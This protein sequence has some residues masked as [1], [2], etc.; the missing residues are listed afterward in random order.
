MKH[1]QYIIL[2]L[3]F[4]NWG[5]KE[6]APLPQSEGTPVF[7]P[8]LISYPS[9]QK[10]QL[11]WWWVSWDVN[12][13]PAR[14]E[15][16]SFEVLGSDV[17]AD[18][19]EVIGTV[20]ADQVDYEVSNVENGKPYYFAIRATANGGLSTVSKTVMVIPGTPS[21]PQPLIPDSQE[22]R[23]HASWSPDGNKIA[24]EVENVSDV[25]FPSANGPGIYIFDLD[26]QSSVFLVDG[27]SPDWSPD[28]SKIALYN[29]LSASNSFDTFISTIDTDGT[30]LTLE[31]GGG[32]YFHSPEWD[33][34]GENIICLVGPDSAGPF[35]VIRIPINGFAPEIRL[36]TKVS[37]ITDSEVNAVQQSP[38]NPVPTPDG[39]GVTYSKWIFN[40]NSYIQ[41][42]FVHS[43]ETDIPLDA[44]PSIYNDAKPAYSPDGTKIA[45]LSDRSGAW[46]IWVLDIAANSYQQLTDGQGLELLHDKGKIE[47][48][49]TE[50]RI[51]FTGKPTSGYANIY[52]LTTE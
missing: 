15:P 31:R 48:H 34:E 42:I 17:S 32:E 27:R 49:P 4:V 24:V 26:A 50:N 5:C 36:N 51:L 23:V 30:S 8:Q 11:E 21:P 43:F 12:V 19:L 3:L 29:T 28:G 40:Q 33:I 52:T 41:R 20:D 1:C 25:S 6:E 38:T 7:Q 9:D 46:A 35:D 37:A 45:F 44:F 47:W 2:L 13:E 10:I 39:L 14:L 22:N 18:E 16:E